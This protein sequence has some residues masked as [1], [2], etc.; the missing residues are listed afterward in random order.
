M[1]MLHLKNNDLWIL[2]YIFLGI[3]QAMWTNLSAFPPLPLRL[4]MNVAVFVPMFT[5][6]DCAVFGIPF[7]MILRGQLGTAYQYLPDIYSYYTY[8]SLLLFLLIIHYKKYF[9]ANLKSYLPLLSIIIYM[10]I[11]DIL[12]ISECGKYVVHL[13]IAFLYLL[14]INSK[15]DSRNLFVA[16]VSVCTLL[17]VYYLIMYNQFLDTWDVKEGIER[18]GWNDPNYFSTFLGIGLLLATFQLLGYV[19]N[20]FVL[21]RPII[22]IAAIGIIFLAIV[23]TASRA[24]FIAA[25][26]ILLFAI[27]KSR[28]KLSTVLLAFLIIVVSIF[29]MY[30]NGVFDTLLYRLVEQG[31]MDTGGERTTIWANVIQNYDDQNFLTQLFG[32]GYWHRV[33]LSDGHEV[34]NEFIAFW[35]D[36]GY[37]GFILFAVM[38][39]SMLSKN[40]QTY[41]IRNLSVLYYIL[42]IISLSPFQFINVGFFIAWIISLK[43]PSMS[44][45][46]EE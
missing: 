30:K 16:L 35:A 41:K 11:I 14:L 19:H 22:L 31:N 3:I 8:I 20:D 29:V 33:Q 1:T 13:F 43:L 36:Y 17:A 39:L 24:G 38:I 25:S 18:S 44:G 10:W 15:E 4:L 6:K 9:L 46:S 12:G 32:G 34:H 26:L 7:F 2:Y 37:I 23:L 5:R 42:M 45:V 27:I 21:F 40:N 28:P